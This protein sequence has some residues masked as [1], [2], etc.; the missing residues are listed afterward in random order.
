[1]TI[2]SHGEQWRAW[3]LENLARYC[4]PKSLLADM[5]RDGWK[6]RDAIAAIDEGLKLL[7]RESSWRVTYPSQRLV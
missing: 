2:D 7:G 4:Y 5:T 1:M 3:I 6:Q